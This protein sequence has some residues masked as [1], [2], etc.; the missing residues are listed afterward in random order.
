MLPIEELGYC[1][2]EPD[3]YC[4]LLTMS[5]SK[6]IYTL[7]VG[8]FKLFLSTLKVSVLFEGM[9]AEPPFFNSLPLMSLNFFFKFTGFVVT[10]KWTLL[11]MGID[12]IEEVPA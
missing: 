5:T 12:A 1:G 10:G 4:F 3:C 11:T 6:S 7:Y 9:M 8:S 2:L